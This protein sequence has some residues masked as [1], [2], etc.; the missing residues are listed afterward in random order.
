[1][2]ATHP[3]YSILRASLLFFP[4]LLEQFFRVRFGW[5][6]EKNVMLE[7]QLTHLHFVMKFITWT[8]AHWRMA[9]P[10]KVSLSAF[11]SVSNE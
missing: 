6:L 1:M 7:V 9:E 5:G 8:I 4:S 2:Y 10:K 3:R 11:A